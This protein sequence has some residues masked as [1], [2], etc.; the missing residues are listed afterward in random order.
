MLSSIADALSPMAEKSNIRVALDAGI[1]ELPEIVGDLAKLRQGI[2]NL[3]HNAIKFSPQGGQVQIS[4]KV[5]NGILS[6]RIKDEGIGIARGD[7]NVIARPFA[8]QR[9]AFDGTHQG[10]GIGLPFAKTIIELHGGTLD[11]DSAQGKGT[12]VIVNLPLPRKE[13]TL[14]VEDAA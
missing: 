8:R 3:V 11:I 1:L 4:S 14:E 12:T 7:Q 6:L 13:E 2:S 5:E 9:K 10:A